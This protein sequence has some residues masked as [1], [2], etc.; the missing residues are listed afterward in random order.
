MSQRC[1]IYTRMIYAIRFTGMLLIGVWVSVPLSAYSAAG[2]VTCHVDKT[3]GF[4][5]GHASGSERCTLCH[6]GDAAAQTKTD[7][8]QGLLGFPGN[9]SNAQQACGSCHPKQVSS[10][11]KSFMH[12]GKGMVHVTRQVVDEPG[13]AKGSADLS[14]LGRTPADTLLRK[15][16]A[17]CHLGQD[18]KQHALDAVK[19]RGGGCLACHINAYP[20]SGHPQLTL[21]VSDERC[22]GCHSRSARISLNYAGLAELT[23]SAIGPENLHTLGRLS[24]GRLVKRKTADIHHQAG[25]SCIDCHTVKG[26]MGSAHGMRHREEAVDV[27]CADCHDNRSQRVRIEHWPADTAGFLNRIPFEHGAQREF[28]KTG[29]FGTPIWNV[30]IT[31]DPK[32]GSELFYM[33]RKNGGKRLR[34]PQMSAAS[35]PLAREHERLTCAACHAQ[36]AP[37]CYGCHLSFTEGQRQWDHVERRATQGR[38]QQKRW[39]FRHDLPTLGVTADNRVSPFIPGMIFTIDHPQWE[40]T[41]FRRLFASISP[42]TVGK[43]RSCESCHRAPLAL[44][45]GQGHLLTLHGKRGFKS[46]RDALVDGLPADA[47]TEWD[48]PRPGVG[49]RDGERSFSSNEIKRVLNVEIPRSSKR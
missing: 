35:H 11:L 9:L 3:H 22:F 40:Q 30:E 44:G 25:M 17:G 12:S 23:E 15:L 2:C 38:W 41:K 49:T 26:L 19:D 14:H 32:S 37:Q 1:Q 47:W 10:V 27:A 42:H 31:T 28:L 18:K 21:K 6:R 20:E 33:H 16:C 13:E 8:H 34:I 43:S 36:W 48:A 45:L 29:R 46:R 24:D 5:K 7:A 4:S 39:D